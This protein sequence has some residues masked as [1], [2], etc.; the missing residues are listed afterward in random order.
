MILYLDLQ[1]Q[2]NSTEL[3]ESEEINNKQIWA[4]SFL[5]DHAL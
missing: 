2:S 5:L 1:Q 3:I 4:N